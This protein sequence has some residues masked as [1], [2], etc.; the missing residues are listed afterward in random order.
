MLVELKIKQLSALNSKHLR[1]TLLS[2]QCHPPLAEGGWRFREIG[3][4][5]VDLKFSGFRGGG[6]APKWWI[7]TFSRGVVNFWNKS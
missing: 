4:Q 2:R 3:I 1:S 7:D 5:G 6:L